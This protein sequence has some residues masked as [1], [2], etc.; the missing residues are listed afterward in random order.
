MTIVKKNCFTKNE[1]LKQSRKRINHFNTVED[2]A[3]QIASLAFGEYNL[4]D[5]LDTRIKSPEL[6]I[7]TGTCSIV[8]SNTFMSNQYF[9]KF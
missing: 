8:F 5:I 6:E 4:I 2:S 9:T 1:R 3:Q 7:D